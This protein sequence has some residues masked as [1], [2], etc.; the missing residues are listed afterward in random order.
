M[1]GQLNCAYFGL[2]KRKHA[3]ECD[4]QDNKVK[5]KTKKEQQQQLNP[6]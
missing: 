5:K 4:R 6:E 2:Y 3:C 1:Y